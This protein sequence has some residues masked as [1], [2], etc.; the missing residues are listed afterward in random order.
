ML[1]ALAW[2]TISLPYVYSHQQNQKE[3]KKVLPCEKDA[4]GEEGNPFAG[5]NEEKTESGS[6]TLSEL[7]HELLIHH[8]YPDVITKSFKYHSSDLYLSFHPELVAPPPKA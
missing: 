6:N 8:H 4:A 1:L 3:I 2:L 5:N 7:L